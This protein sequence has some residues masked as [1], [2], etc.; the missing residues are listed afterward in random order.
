VTAS[1]LQL[2]AALALLNDTRSLKRRSGAKQL[3][4]RKDPAAGPAL[5]AVLQKEVQ[6][7]RTWETQYQMIMALGECQYA[8][9]L[10]YLQSLAQQRF[11][12]TM[13]YT[14]L[15][16]AIVRLGRAHEH[17]PA[18]ALALL[19]THNDMLIAGAFRA[20]AMLRLKPSQA[21]VEQIIQHALRQS[22][23]DQVHFWVAAAA[24]GWHGPLVEQ[25]LAGAVN[26]SSDTTRRAA[27]AAQQKQYL[28]WSPL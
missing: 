13:I 18:P 22:P 12:A 16:D 3:R 14:A 11:E 6:D 19:H 20:V 17:D 25:F 7:H 15:G 26:S 1:H 8:P 2:A 23:Y 21:E 10:P 5:L 27:L 4:K 24:P 28:K 9:A